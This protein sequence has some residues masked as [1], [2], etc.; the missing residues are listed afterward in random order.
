MNAV[1]GIAARLGRDLLVFVVVIALLALAPLF[2]TRFELG[3]A[4]QMLLFAL[5][6]VAWNVMGGYA[7]QFSFGHAAYFGIGAYISAYLVIHGGVSPW[8]GMLPGAALAA[9]LGL[10]IGYLS[11]H[12][13]LKGVF[14]ALVT[15]AF[16][17]MLHLLTTNLSPLNGSTGLNIPLISGSSWVM[18]QFPLGSANYYYVILLLLAFS[19]LVVML[20]MRSRPGY[21]INALRED[22][23][24]AAALGIDP[25]RY[26]LLAS[27][28]SAALTALGGAFYAQ[29]LLYIN[30]DLAFGATVSIQILLPAILGGVRTIWGPVVGAFIITLLGQ[31]TVALVHTPPPFL[32]ALAGRS[33]LDVMLYGLV[34][35]LIIVLVPQGIFG[36]IRARARP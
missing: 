31:A 4:V 23:E 18:I 2:L 24:A 12:Y 16:A 10:L 11:F 34:L 19:L 21:F 5:L 20:L 27:A 13:G 32:S 9:L 25:L 8:V 17:E 30:P 7:G 6:A 22:E 28:I 15:F 1:K 35:I 29:Y 26:K 33:G 36:A 3:I 14:F